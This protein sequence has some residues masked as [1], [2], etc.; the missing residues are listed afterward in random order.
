MSPPPFALKRFALCFIQKGFPV[1]SPPPTP[2]PG[3]F[4]AILKVEHMRAKKGN[5]AF[6]IFTFVGKEKISIENKAMH[7]SICLI[8]SCRT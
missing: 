1:E 3:G 2:Q 7:K 4:F 8:Y 5:K 6:Q